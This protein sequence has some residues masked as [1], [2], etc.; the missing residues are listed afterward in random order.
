MHVG[1]CFHSLI[2]YNWGK[3]LYTCSCGDKLLLYGEPSSPK[4]SEGVTGSYLPYR[5]SVTNCHL[6]TTFLFKNIPVLVV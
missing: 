4:G 6:L 2:S 1:T 5:L 3:A